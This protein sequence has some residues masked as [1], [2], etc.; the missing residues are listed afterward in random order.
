MSS[1]SS[2]LGYFTFK[3][4]ILSY[5]FKKILYALKVADLEVLLLLVVV[6]SLSVKFYN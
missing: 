3:P 5:S 2:A 6:F 4:V 1:A